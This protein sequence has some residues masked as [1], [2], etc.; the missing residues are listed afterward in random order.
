MTAASGLC[1]MQAL[2][3]QHEG[4]T[5]A[6]TVD[7]PP[8]LTHPHDSLP[9][10]VRLFKA[11]NIARQHR[12]AGKGENLKNILPPSLRGQAAPELM[13]EAARLAEHGRDLPDGWDLGSTHAP[14]MHTFLHGNKQ[15]ELRNKEIC[16]K[17]SVWM[18]GK[19]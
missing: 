3:V 14:S 8:P 4:G 1:R 15:A 7:T 2:V 18:L 11:A 9:C 6:G 10:H 19:S 16:A 12:S 5:P 13:L 17:N